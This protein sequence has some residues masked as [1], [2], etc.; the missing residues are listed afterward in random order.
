MKILSI[1][2]VRYNWHS[3]PEQGEDYTER[4]VGRRGVASIKISQEWEGAVEK[5]TD[6][7]V[8]YDNGDIQFQKNINQIIYVEDKNEI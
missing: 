2:S 4:E 5:S 6:V 3:T 1:K 7:I 8:T